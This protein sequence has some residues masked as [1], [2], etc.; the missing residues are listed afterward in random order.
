MS[1]GAK[2]ALDDVERNEWDGVSIKL[3]LE[4]QVAGR[5][6][7]AWA[8]V[9]CS[10][11]EPFLR[12]VLGRN[13]TLQD[14]Q[15]WGWE[16]GEGGEGAGEEGEGRLLEQVPAPLTVRFP[17]R[18][19][20]SPASSAGFPVNLPHCPPTPIVIQPSLAGPALNRAS[21][22]ALS[23]SS[24]EKAVCGYSRRRGKT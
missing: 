20:V 22:G 24:T 15:G 16:V 18:G 6:R 9:C 19:S 3:Y 10:C 7:R 8:A 11:S 13:Q 12:L 23:S 5:G 1:R 4:E 2:A 14:Q 17:V 21:A